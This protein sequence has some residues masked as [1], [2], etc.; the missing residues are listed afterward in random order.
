METLT[1]RVGNPYLPMLVAAVLA[2]VACVALT[3]APEAAALTTLEPEEKP[4]IVLDVTGEMA[5]GER[6]VLDV[7]NL[8]SYLRS[9]T[10]VPAEFVLYLDGR[11]IEG[12]VPSLVP[13]HTPDHEQ[14]AFD[15]KRTEQSQSAWSALLGS[16]PPSFQRPVTVSFGYGKE[17]PFETRAAPANL[18]IIRM[19]AWGW[20]FA[21]LFG[22]SLG[23][24]I[25]LAVTKSII[26]EPSDLDE[27]DRPFSLGRSQMA[28]WFF[29]V[30]ASFAF[31]W[32][33][34]GVVP[35]LSGSALALIGISA[36]TA[37]GATLVDTGKEKKDPKVAKEARRRDSGGFAE[38]LL[39]DADG[40]SFHRFQMVIWTL[41]LGVIFVATVYETLAMPEFEGTLLA[42]MGISGGTYV[43]FKFQERQTPTPSVARREHR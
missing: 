20:V 15:V 14:L 9:N 23:A 30:L 25:Y 3:A 17:D 21:A 33:I 38:D 1:H 8:R 29:I 10:R 43:G 40:Y 7:R 28:F 41:V 34:T 27:K 31:I 39:A 32:L 11:P 26:R 6:I 18:H 42:L 4:P 5:L 22:L 2:L 16:P 12:V 36:L 13:G 37:L 19:R 35:P 24:F